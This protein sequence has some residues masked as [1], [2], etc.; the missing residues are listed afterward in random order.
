MRELTPLQARFVQEYLVD[1]NAT[2]AARRA[3]YSNGE[4]GRQLIQNPA[5]KE[6]V[7]RLQKV[8]EI[9]TNVSIGNVIKEL[10]DLYYESREKGESSTAVRCLE[11]LG[12][13][14]GAFS[15]DNQQK[16]NKVMVLMNFKY[17]DEVKE[18]P[19][20]SNLVDT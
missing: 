20:G 6:A 13:H 10:T 15:A 19:L 5:I 2:G 4:Y 8:T 3:G 9:Q 16:D 11:L 1:L 14:V 7:K 18:L 12:K 17:N